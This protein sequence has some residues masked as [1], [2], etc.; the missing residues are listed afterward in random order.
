MALAS[1]VA[2]AGSGEAPPQ[3]GKTVEFNPAFL[4]GGLAMKIDLSRYSRGNPVIPGT[5][6]ADIW[7]NGAWQARRSVRF[8]ANDSASDAM[9]CLSPAD[10]IS[11]GVALS[12]GAAENDDTCRSPGDHVSG[13][14]ASFDVSE[15]RL[16]IEVP[17]ALLMRH[18]PGVVPVDQRD[19]GIS[20]G[21]LGWRL[22]LHR[23][24]LGKRSRMARFLAQESGINAGSWRIRGAG[25]WSASRYTRR[26]VYIE[27]QVEAWQSQ[28]RMGELNVA[29]GAFTPI[30][31]R[32]V[33]LASDA[34]MS[35]DAVTGYK[36]TARG[37]A[38]THARVRVMQGGVLIN[39]ISVPPGPFVIDDL[40]G[41]GRGGDLDVTVE[42]ED[43]GRTSFRVPFFAMPD[44][45]GEGRV[46][47]AFAAGRAGKLSGQEGKVVQGTWRRGFA[48]RTTLY[49]GGRHWAGSTSLLLGGAIDT[50]SGAFA[51][52][53]TGSRI[54]TGS[55]TRRRRHTRAWR[56][57]HGRR[58]QDG[59]SMWVSLVRERGVA[60]PGFDGGR[61]YAEGAS[62]ADERMDIAL[63]RDIASGG[64]IGLNVSQWRTRRHLLS[65]RSAFG[66]SYA[67]A[68]SRGWRRATFDVSLR[69]AVDEASAHLA[70]SVP[71]GVPLAPSFS[72]TGHGSRHDGSRLQVGLAGTSGADS[73]LG[74][75][76]FLGQGA[77]GDRRVGVSASHLSGA[78]E[79][80]VALDRTATAHTESFSS[81]GAFVIHRHGIT[82]AQR[83][84]EA[85]ALVCAPGAAGARLP[86]AAGA[87]LDRRGYGVVSNLAPFRR[88]AVDIDP[89]GLSLDVR[90]MSTRQRVAPTAGALVTLPFDTEVGR[91]ALLIARRPDGSPP[92]FGAD[93]LDEQ[94][95]SVGVVGQAGHI[96]VRNVAAGA[97]LTIRWSDKPEDLCVAQVAGDGE[98]VHGLVR[99]AGVC[100]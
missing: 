98:A 53:F 35:D 10:L 21:L 85:M 38:R 17:Q 96:F 67:L 49:T 44:L 70:V 68:W 26:H 77:R 89:T 43:G 20:S 19:A 52:D 48:G 66:K 36:P 92:A 63:Q 88:N 78:G 16:D 23:S 27:R 72:L 41:L 22:R 25:A 83:L 46:E 97:L 74:Y 5:Y 40:P 100:R 55:V 58:W 11:F 86:A 81:S 31:M 47:A 50:L 99:L 33:S 12:A 13:A 6:D 15:Q 59:T 32:G 1:G 39:E 57:R 8:A 91:T 79:S 69:H 30:R 93:V 71:L 60:L 82:R 51:V 73:E 45:L 34:R 56:A 64:V 62:I 9:P 94:G 84:G 76:A 80:S 95:R 3:Q 65:R 90:L 24:T 42:E 28:W 18:R 29:D 61:G 87:R 7:L 54:A 2:H 75:G 4:P 14:T 37:I